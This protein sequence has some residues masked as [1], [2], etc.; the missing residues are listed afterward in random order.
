MKFK[1]TGVVRDWCL[2][3]AVYAAVT[4]TFH[5]HFKEAALDDN[6]N[7]PIRRRMAIDFH[8]PSEPVQYRY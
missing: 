1:L 2:V 8:G 4:V 3:L 6:K 7:I 5:E